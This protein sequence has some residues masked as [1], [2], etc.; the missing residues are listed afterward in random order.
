MCDALKKTWWAGLCERF[1]AF[2]FVNLELFVCVCSI[3][4]P[5]CTNPLRRVFVIPSILISTLHPIH[6]DERKNLTP[7]RKTQIQ[8]PNGR[9]M[10]G[11]TSS[12]NSPN[13]TA[14]TRPS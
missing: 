2:C 12:L 14:N 1:F 4:C 6:R 3:H 10:H 5:F 8:S 7:P 11:Y 9:A 13:H